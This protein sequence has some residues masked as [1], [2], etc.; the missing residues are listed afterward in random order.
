MG[1]RADRLYE[2]LRGKQAPNVRQIKGLVAQF[3]TCQ[4]PFSFGQPGRRL[5]TLELRRAA[6]FGLNNTP[7]LGGVM[8]S[9][10][11]SLPG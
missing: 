1:L 10:S 9:S 6:P 2:F 4:Q 3:F 11:N 8:Q 7:L 5:S